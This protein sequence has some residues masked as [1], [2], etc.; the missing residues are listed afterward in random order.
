MNS[1]SK[2]LC[3]LM[4]SVTLWLG[5]G[6]QK[7]DE[8]EVQQIAAQIET[9][10][11]ANQEQLQHNAVASAILSYEVAAMTRD[12]A[13]Q[14]GW[15]FLAV[16][17][18]TK[19]RVGLLGEIGKC[20]AELEKIAGK[21]LQIGTFNTPNEYR[22]AQALMMGNVQSNGGRGDG[23]AKLLREEA[24]ALRDALKDAVF[25]G[26]R[27]IEI[28]AIAED[29]ATVVWEVQHFG[30]ANVLRALEELELL[31][32]DALEMERLMID[33]M[34]AELKL[35]ETV[36]KYEVTPPKGKLLLRYQTQSDT[37]AAGL[38]MEAILGVDNLPLGASVRY[39]GNG[40]KDRNDYHK[41]ILGQI[42]TP[43]YFPSE[44]GTLVYPTGFLHLTAPGGFAK[45]QTTKP[46]TLRA[47]ATVTLPDGAVEELEVTC[48]F[49]ICIPV[50]VITP[51]P[52]IPLRRGVPN[53][54]MVDVPDLGVY[55]SPKLEATEATIQPSNIDKRKFRIIPTGSTTTLTISSLTNG[56]RIL[57]D[58][59]TFQVK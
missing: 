2:Y 5:C 57:V 9:L 3:L 6:P 55:F 48:R 14:F 24:L 45:G 22:A 35:A 52:D 26:K 21:D 16:E 59:V 11:K 31:V 25:Q 32:Q 29:S 43:N 34:V 53:E 17:N 8:A 30:E 54:M 44:F 56:Q 23:K 49:V 47:S 50:A 36:Q 41:G 15:M 39:H 7:L 51:S 28:P 27:K 4:L 19:Y 46:Y 40:V 13:H 1:N 18:I 20:R 38:W 10:D 42:F 37:V 12:S 58:R 33:D